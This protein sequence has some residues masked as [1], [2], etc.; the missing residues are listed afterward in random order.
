MKGFLTCK[1]SLLQNSLLYIFIKIILNFN[2][3][4]FLGFWYLKEVEFIW[5]ILQ[6]KMFEIK[7]KWSETFLDFEEVELWNAK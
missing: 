5:A 1:F 2:K 4:N 7:M 6:A 3:W